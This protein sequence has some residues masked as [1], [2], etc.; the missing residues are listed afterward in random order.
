MR[1]SLPDVTLCCVSDVALPQSLRAIRLCH[2][3]AQ[4]AR[5]ILMTSK[6][7][8]P[9]DDI[10]IVRTEPIKSRV[11]YSRLVLSG[12]HPHVQTSHVLLVQWDG[13][14]LDASQ[15]KPEFLQYDYIGAPWIHFADQMAVG[16]GGFSLRSSRMLR[17]C[18][19]LASPGNE[20]E[21]TFICRTSRAILEDKFGLRFAPVELAKQFA[22]E[23]G[24]PS[25]REFGFHGVFN[26]L[27]VMPVRDAL[28]LVCSVE[29]GLLR[30]SDRMDLLRDGLRKAGLVR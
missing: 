25:G 8:L 13:Y 27:K 11:D 24:A 26:F 9:S 16:N 28:R 19:N 30:R 17:A 21:D 20:A 1:L 2:D 6:P 12:L 29:R 22:F 14:L 4:F 23:R 10:E 3:Q 7:I 18:A 5:S 15:W